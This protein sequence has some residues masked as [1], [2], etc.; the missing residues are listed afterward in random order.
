MGQDFFIADT[1]FGDE[2]IIRYE[3]SIA[4]LTASSARDIRAGENLPIVLTMS[5]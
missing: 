3:K 1:H 5:R 2:R 4:A